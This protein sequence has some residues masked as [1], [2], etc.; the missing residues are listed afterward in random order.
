MNLL[1]SLLDAIVRLEGDALVMHVGEKPYVVTTSSPLDTPRGPLSWGQVELSSR[2]LT[3]DAV[4]GM[5][6]QILPLEERQALEKM[7]A[8]QYDIQQTADSDERFSVIAARGGDDVWLEVRRRPKPEP[9]QEAA[10]EPAPAMEVPPWAAEM[11]SASAPTPA[12]VESAPAVASPTSELVPE[13]QI[14]IDQDDEEEVIEI[15]LDGVA[16]PETPAAAPVPPIEV[17]QEVSQSVPTDDEVDALVAAMTPPAATRIETPEESDEAIEI[18]LELLA[19]SDVGSSVPASNVIEFI[20]PGAPPA[21]QPFASN[22]REWVAAPDVAEHDAA[23]FSEPAASSEAAVAAD[24]PTTVPVA[25]LRPSAPVISTFEPPAGPAPAIVEPVIASE[26]VT[27]VADA[28]SLLPDAAIAAAQAAVP[29][30]AA[31]AAQS[32]AIAEARA[33]IEAFALTPP[34]LLAADA[35][36]DAEELDAAVTAAEFAAADTSAMHVL[37]FDAPSEH[38][39]ISG[40]ATAKTMEPVVHAERAAPAAAVAAPVIIDAHAPS[41]AMAVAAAAAALEAAAHAHANTEEHARAEN[42][43]AASA[44]LP[45]APAVAPVSSTAAPAPVL[46]PA[47]SVSLPVAAQPTLVQPHAAPIETPAVPLRV[48]APAIAARVHE[49]STAAVPPVSEAQPA[50]TIEVSPAAARVVEAPAPPVPVNVE[51]PAPPPAVVTARAAE[52]TLAAASMTRDAAPTVDEPRPGVVVPISRSPVRPETPAQLPMA[53]LAPLE[54][55]L[56]IAAARG[57]STVYVVAQSKPMIR[58]DGEISVLESEAT[59]STADV[60]RVVMD[61]APAAR[62]RD[63]AAGPVEWMSDVAEVGRV[64]CVTFRDHRGPGVI[65]RMIPPRAISADQ[66]GL[67]AEVQSLCAMPD[68]LVLVAGARASG[69]STL[70]SAFVDLINR[71]RSDHV[72]TIESQIGFVHESRRAFVSQ[73]EVRGDAEAAAAAVRS[74]FREDP[75]VL[76]IEDLRTAEIVSVAI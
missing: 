68:G 69:K 7:G 58:V 51:L 63:V 40:P 3:L 42:L 53:S 50:S 23:L 1:E 18:P 57:A 27:S 19:D 15:S 56:R 65:F 49:R 32:A 67:T 29:A 66:L 60:E 4:L 5:L 10:A 70:L 28:E 14:G 16:A 11:Q 74:A 48:E 9:V 38:V 76:V 73:R 75:D 17:V 46:Q 72:I 24:I 45:P 41:D 8:V 39:A 35:I 13:A 47:A 59:F 20:L 22:E 44:T 31:T 64:R 2:V 54:H 21:E 62:G 52:P 61:L 71:T 36:S 37:P 12:S 33:A 30:D 26:L 43:P 6:G 25:P 34:E 55:M